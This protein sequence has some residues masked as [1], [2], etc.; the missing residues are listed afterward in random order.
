M[1]E[2]VRG[3]WVT[4]EPRYADRAFQLDA[5]MVIFDTGESLAVHPLQAIDTTRSAEG[6]LLE[7]RYRS[8]GL[9]YAFDL[10]YR[11][12]TETT[13]RF[14]NQPEITWRRTDRPLY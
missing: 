1:P 8:E 4:D 9:L 7:L 11:T 14:K 2:E 3:V 13:I 5:D 6:T 10:F 12:D